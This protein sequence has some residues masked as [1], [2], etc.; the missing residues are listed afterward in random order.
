MQEPLCWKLTRHQGSWHREAYM[1][2]LFRG[3]PRVVRNYDT[4]PTMVG[5]RV[6]YA[7]VL[8]FAEH[9]DFHGSACYSYGHFKR[10]RIL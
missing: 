8:E 4:F 3:H 5:R 7:V 10:L 2:E 1:A 6:S 9:G